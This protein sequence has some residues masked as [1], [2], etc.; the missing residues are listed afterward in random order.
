MLTCLYTMIRLACKMLDLRLIYAKYCSRGEFSISWAQ[1]YKLS[2]HNCCR[3]AILIERTEAG[4]TARVEQRAINS[5]FALVSSSIWSFSA[6][7]SEVTSSTVHEEQRECAFAKNPMYHESNLVHASSQPQTCFMW[8]GSHWI[9]LVSHPLE[10]HLSAGLWIGRS[11]WSWPK[12]ALK[13]FRNVWRH[14]VAMWLCLNNEICQ[15]FIRQCMWC[16]IDIKS[17]FG[18]TSDDEGLTFGA[19]ACDGFWMAVSGNGVLQNHTL[20]NCN[21]HDLLE[22]HA[23]ISTFPCQIRNLLARYSACQKTHQLSSK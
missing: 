1:I 18:T 13:R 4:L 14:K 21:G 5:W 10:M 20:A 17:S 7:T 3:K 6:L 19:E 8:L 16:I 23:V 2:S 11:T 12:L 22:A 9:L 15:C